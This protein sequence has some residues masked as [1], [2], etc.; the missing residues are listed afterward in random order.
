MMSKKDSRA[1]DRNVHKLEE[2]PIYMMHRIDSEVKARIA[3]G[4][5][6]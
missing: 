2:L 4:S 5:I 1:K 6:R 3:E